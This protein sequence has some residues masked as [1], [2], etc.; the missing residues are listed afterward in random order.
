[1]RILLADDQRLLRDGIRPFLVTLSSDTRLFEAGTFDEAI[2]VV[3]EEGA[4]DLAV[5]GQALPGMDGL[6]GV[7]AF[8]KRFPTTRVVLLTA[9]V[10]PQLILAAVAA[11]AQGIILKTISGENMLNA[12]RMVVSGEIYMPAESVIA[13][14]KAMNF[15]A[16]PNGSSASENN[17]KAPFSSG[18]SQV[19]PLL[20]DGLS[21]KLIAQRLGIEE[22][23]VKARLRSIYKKM[24]VF[25]RAQAVMALLSHGYTGSPPILR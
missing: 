10:D 23:A 12:L 19:V 6:V 15:F 11:G 22:A 1:M 8:S 18:E 7:L 25:N 5:L 16:I 21:N 4:I 2:Q 13:L 24:G 17:G 9:V 20:L 14:A 3:A